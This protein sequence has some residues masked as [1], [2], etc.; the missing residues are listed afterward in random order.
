MLLSGYFKLKYKH[1]TFKHWPPKLSHV[2]F[3]LHI[4]YLPTYLPSKVVNLVHNA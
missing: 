4:G 3:N 1:V 2:T